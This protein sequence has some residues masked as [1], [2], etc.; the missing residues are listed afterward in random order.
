MKRPKKLSATFVKNVS[1]PGRYGDGRG[2]FG[3][4]LLVKPMANG[5]VSKTWAQRLRINGRLTSVGLGRFPLVNLKEARQAAFENARA[6]TQGKNPRASASTP[7]F[8]EAAEKVIQ[9]YE[10]TW[11]N[12]RTGKDWKASLRDYAQPR[13]GRKRVDTINTADVMSVLLPIWTNKP[14]TA[15]R[16]RRRISAIFK[17]SIAQG[18][19]SDDPAGDAISKALPRSNGQRKHMKALPYAEVSDALAK[20]RASGAHPGTKLCFEFLVLTATRSG[21]ARLATWDE[22]DF[23]KKV[24][25]IPPERMKMAREHRIPLSKHALK[26][27]AKAQKL[28]DGSGL[29]FPSITGK[30]LSDNTLSKLLRDLKIPA[31]P[32]GFRS[33][34]R[35]WTGEQSVPREVA[36]ACLAHVVGGVEGS[37]FRSDLFQLRRKV[38]QDWADYLGQS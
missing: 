36:E 6:V 5:R 16:L 38:M 11:R 10:P 14:E 30:P 26:V 13:L 23:E 35:N 18:Y 37:Y 7:S 15:R 3:L 2:G 24:W 20:I 28:A 9:I 4:S 29:I 34:L 12:A 8:A 17:W 32:H 19:R 21:E 27:L 25:T 33:S 31:V 1:E 22:I